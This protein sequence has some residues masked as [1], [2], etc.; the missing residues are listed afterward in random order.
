MKKSAFS[1]LESAIEELVRKFDDS[2]RTR[3][4]REEDAR[5]VMDAI[6]DAVIIHRDDKIIFANRAALTLLEAGGPDDVMGISYHDLLSRD[7]RD[8]PVH[9]KGMD[10]TGKTVEY[11]RQ[12]I[13]GLKGGARW[14]ETVTVPVK[15]EERNAYQVTARYI[16]EKNIVEEEPENSIIE[17]SLSKIEMDALLKCAPIILEGDDFLRAVEKIF[18]ECKNIMR[19]GSGYVA[20]LNED[21]T[22]HEVLFLDSGGSPYTFNSEA[23]VLVRSLMER[24]LSKGEV[25]YENDCQE[26]IKNPASPGK[27]IP[28]HNAIFAPLAVEEKQVGMMGL[29]NKE[30]GFTP[31]DAQT[32]RAFAKYA[33]IAL[34][35]TRGQE[36]LRKSEER[37][38][39]LFENMSSGVA[40]YEAVDGGTDFVFKSINSAGAKICN[41]PVDEIVG[42]KVT[43][44]FSGVV[45]MGLLDTFKRVYATGI[46]EDLPST[47]YRD[48]RLTFWVDNHM[49]MLPSGELVAIFDDVTA[50]K[51]AEEEMRS[52]EQQYFQ[53]QKLESIGRLA[54]GIAHDFNNI[55]VGIMGYAELLK[56]QFPDESTAEGEAAEI[57]LHGADR[58]AKLT[59]QLLG[60]ARKGKFNPVPLNVNDV[61]R[62]TIRVSEKI[63]DKRIDVILNLNEDVSLIMADRHQM[64]QVFTNIIIN[65]KDAMP[66]GGT[67]MVKTANKRLGR[68]LKKYKG[69]YEPGEYVEVEISDTGIGIPEALL[70]HIFEPFF[71]T[72]G[73]GKGTGL[74]LATAYGIIKNH[75]GYISADGRPGKG[76]RFNILLP[77]SG[78]S[79]FPADDEEQI[80]EGQGGILVV[81]DEEDV[82]KLACRMLNTLG[83]TTIQAGN[84]KDALEIYSQKGDEID[85]VILDIIMPVL[86]G[87]ETLEMLK[88]MNPTIKIVIS[89]GYSQD[90]QAAELMEMGVSAY[91]Q[92]PY[93]IREL[94]KVVQEILQDKDK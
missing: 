12:R 51:K 79:V 46:P 6:P 26:R 54:G 44:L 11:L 24:A 45:G 68:G 39:L 14:V 33:A 35:N 28:L 49:F 71:T 50:R 15:Y 2:M 8:A 29:A 25:V 32:M 31:D 88:T 13:V 64:E 20:L 85:V 4:Q 70:G 72:K 89:S 38:K 34:K 30:G 3:R 47:V 75:K 69:E 53:A 78:Q 82:R 60:F 76:A 84:G 83:Y 23:P 18:A 56:M 27:D 77:A 93:S 21:G 48:D 57:I 37:Y 61:I 86:S 42:R 22:D 65:A 80:M 52:Y 66:N 59:Q 87:K 73:E 41:L 1:K 81:D 36:A 91:I 74:G 63:F 94:S 17:K 5:A 43:T 67:L 58:A 7:D 92:K 9:G 16:V 55:L 19:A 90:D 10:K 62:D 40:V